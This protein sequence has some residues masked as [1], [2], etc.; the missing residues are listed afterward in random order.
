MTGNLSGDDYD[1]D[2]NTLLRSYDQETDP[3]IF[4]FI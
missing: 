1:Y 2:F 3:D 4:V